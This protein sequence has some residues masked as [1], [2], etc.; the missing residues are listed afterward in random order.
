MDSLEEVANNVKGAESLIYIKQ[1]LKENPQFAYKF[2]MIFNRPIPNKTE[3]YIDSKGNPRTNVTNLSAHPADV[4]FNKLDNTVR[5][6][7][8]PKAK[9]AISHLMNILDFTKNNITYGD[10]TE[11][12]FVYKIYKIA[13]LVI[14]NITVDAI[15][16]YA[17]GEIKL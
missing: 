9:K 7:S 12:E 14:P 6:I 13:K 2:R 16:Q 8:I 15:K 17:R 3:T 11:E 10:T 1:Y 5:N 4:I